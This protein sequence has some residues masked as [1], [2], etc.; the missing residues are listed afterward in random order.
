[1][2]T[3]NSNFCRSKS[4]SFLLPFPL[5][6]E[7]TITSTPAITVSRFCFPH[8]ASAGCLF[9]IS[10]KSSIST[11]CCCSL[12]SRLFRQTFFVHLLMNGLPLPPS[13]ARLLPARHRI[14]HQKQTKH[15]MC[16]QP[17]QEL[18]RGVYTSRYFRRRIHTFWTEEIKLG[19][20]GGGRQSSEK[21]SKQLLLG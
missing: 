8:T 18:H 19:P 17:N 11:F 13:P 5:G 1:M 15:K 3:D 6:Q 10:W 2:V 20:R 7:N 21:S 4:S 16:Y 14:S 12:P 9:S